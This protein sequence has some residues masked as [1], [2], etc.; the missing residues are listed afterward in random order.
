MNQLQKI[1]SYQN[2]EV[3]TVIKDGQPYFVA[4]DVC[5]VLEI[6]KH[7]DAVSRLNDSQRGSVLVDTLGGRQEMAAINEAGVYKLVFTSRKPEA[8]RFTDWIASEVLP[9]IRKHGMYAKDQHAALGDLSPQLQ[10]LINMEIKQNQLAA[11]IES[12]QEELQGI[13]EVVTIIP[14][15]TWREDTNRLIRKVGKKLDDYQEPMRLIYKAL[16][17]RANCNLKIRL[18]NMRARAALE[19]VCKSKINDMNYLDVIANDVK[20][21][22]I[23]IAIVK[24][25]AIKNGVSV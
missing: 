14:G 5:D 3:R 4:K 16:G 17:E 25:M 6:E 24:E 2:K 7:R 18:E 8:E 23:Y 13:R 15:D 1:F 10:L 11:V 22:E 19:G 21:K 20:L 12:T 9:S